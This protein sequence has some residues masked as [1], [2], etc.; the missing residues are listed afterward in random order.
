[1]K[2]PA[3]DAPNKALQLTARSQV[4]LFPLSLDED[5]APQLKAGVSG[6]PHGWL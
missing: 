4:I 1:M 2:G 6:Q 3:Q 5:R